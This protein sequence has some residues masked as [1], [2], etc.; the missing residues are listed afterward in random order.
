MTCGGVYILSSGES[1]KSQSLNFVYDRTLCKRVC[2]FH[3]LDQ[4]KNTKNQDD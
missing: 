1:I 4:A 2:L 3:Q